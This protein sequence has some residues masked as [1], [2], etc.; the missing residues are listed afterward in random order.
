MS[1]PSNPAMWVVFKR[2]ICN[3]QTHPKNPRLPINKCNEVHGACCH[4]PR[5]HRFEQSGT[6]NNSTDESDRTKGS[7]WP[8]STSSQGSGDSQSTLGSFIDHRESLMLDIGEP[9][10]SNY[11]NNKVNR[12]L[13]CSQLLD[14][15]TDLPQVD[16][17]LGKPLEEKSPQDNFEPESVDEWTVV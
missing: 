8:N 10:M 14:L 7:N 5:F 11:W 3:P 2:M 12:L 16:H 15:Q 9:V 17:N 13:A 6:A 4:K 1:Y